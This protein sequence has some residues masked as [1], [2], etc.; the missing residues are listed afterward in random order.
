MA[1]KLAVQK[2]KSDR[3]FGQRRNQPK[4]FR[5]G[6]Y[7][8]VSTNDQQSLPMQSRAPREYAA[9]RGCTIALQVREVNSGATRREACRDRM[10][11]RSLT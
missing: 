10:I 1:E 3:V 7:A 9:R 6:L 4:M 8:R 11:P 2:L 5:V